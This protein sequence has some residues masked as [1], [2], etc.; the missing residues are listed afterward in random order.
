LLQPEE[1]ADG[2]ATYPAQRL[3]EAVQNDSDAYRSQ[4][5][6]FSQ[7]T[8]LFFADESTL[9]SL[10]ERAI[11]DD[12]WRSSEIDRVRGPVE[13]GMGMESFV[14]RTLALVRDG[15]EAT[16]TADPAPTG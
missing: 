7:M 16:A 1:F 10:L 15:L 2:Y 14:E 8:P 4:R 6:L 13:R 12:A 3:R 5:K 9:E 11:E